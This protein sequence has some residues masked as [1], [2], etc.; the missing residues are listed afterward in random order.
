MWPKRE[1]ALN[2]IVLGPGQGPLCRA[3]KAEQGFQMESTAETFSTLKAIVQ[4]LFQP[5]TRTYS[6][7]T[8]AASAATGQ[9]TSSTRYVGHRRWL[10]L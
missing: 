9:S 6:V 7:P 5:S 4:V 2:I 8:D 10:L 1:L 3:A